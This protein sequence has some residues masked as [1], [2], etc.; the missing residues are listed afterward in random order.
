MHLDDF[1][2]S[3]YIDFLNP[4]VLVHQ[5]A[6]GQDH[7]G[8]EDPTAKHA[9]THTHTHTHTNARARVHTHT[10]SG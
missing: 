6:I 8:E 7:H 3:L 10:A 4:Y 5:M 9:N 1:H 2:N